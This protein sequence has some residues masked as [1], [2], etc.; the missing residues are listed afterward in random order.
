MLLRWGSLT[1]LILAD[2]LCV[3]LSV[4]LLKTVSEVERKL[5]LRTSVISLL[6]QSSFCILFTCLLFSL[7]NIIFQ[8]N[9]IRLIV[10]HLILQRRTL[11]DSFSEDMESDEVKEL[12]E[13]I[14]HLETEVEMRTAQIND[15]QQKL[16][17]VD[18][19]M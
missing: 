11:N 4:W 19:G 8:L 2:I 14:K 12:K 18:G 13:E 6:F 16:L 7:L 5:V 10:W 9:H 17:D 1:E 15:L 3:H